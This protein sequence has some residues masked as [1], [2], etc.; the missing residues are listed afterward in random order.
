MDI[1]EQIFQKV[2]ETLKGDDLFSKICLGEATKDEKEKFSKNM[3]ASEELQ[4]KLQECCSIGYDIA[5]QFDK[6]DVFT[7]IL[8]QLKLLNEK[9]DKLL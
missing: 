1:N 7:E 9:V 6:K 8:E 4:E 5:S 3:G 2:K